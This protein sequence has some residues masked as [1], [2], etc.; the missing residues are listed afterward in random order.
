MSRLLS[1]IFFSVSALFVLRL[2]VA[3]IGGGDRGLDS[4]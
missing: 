1:R 3:F 2:A 4:P